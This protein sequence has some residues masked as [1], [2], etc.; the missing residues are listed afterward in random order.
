MARTV[1]VELGR[2]SYDIAIGVD[3][4]VGTTLPAGGGH[5][6]L[7]VSDSNVDPIYGAACAEKLRRRGMETVRFVVPAGESS[8]C[9]EQLFRIYDAAVKAG[10]DRS[11]CIVALGGGMVGDLAGFASATFMR[12]IRLI[13]VPTSLLAMVDSAVGGKTAIN[14]PQGKNLV[15]SFH[16]PVEVV[17]DLGTL[18]TLPEREY[19]SGLAEVVKCGIIADAGLFGFLEENIRGVAGRDPAV[20]EDVIGRC[21]SLK[22]RVVSGDER[23]KGLRGIL[24]FGHTMG[25]AVEKAFGYAGMLHGEA[26]S[27]GMVYASALSVK[28]ARLPEKDHGR[29]VSLLERLGLP[30]RFGDEPPEW[31]DLRR[32]MAV[33]KKSR[34]GTPRFVLADRIGSVIL[35][36]EVPDDVLADT[37]GDMSCQK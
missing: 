1:H 30:V 27:L 33:D 11:S 20:M 10:L 22:A 28:R 9:G 32:T 6:G 5:R 34:G 31:N 12:G 17:E 14:L 26:V 23:E 37:L 2:R 19:L 7:V 13:Q 18:K 21:C 16:Q 4:P 8:K 24:N 3:L 36:C 15:G 35:G 29:I 25:H